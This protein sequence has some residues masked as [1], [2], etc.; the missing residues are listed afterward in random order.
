MSIVKNSTSNVCVLPPVYPIT[1]TRIA[2]LS[3]LEQV[4]RLVDGG[5]TLVQLREKHASP[6]EFYAAAVQCVAYARPSGLKIIINDRV[7][8][9]LMTNADG[10]HLG[11][12]DMPPAAARQVLGPDKIIGYSTHSVDQ[13]I[14]AAAS[15]ADYIAIGPVFE[16]RTKTDPDTAVGLDGVTAVRAAIGNVPLVAIGGIDAENISEVLGAGANS[17]AVISCILA[18]PARINLAIQRLFA[19]AVV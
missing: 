11:Q 17:A 4:K 10:V 6:R 7:D 9:A 2:G 8:I 1:D 16:T 15:D 3:H 14:A 18:E 12:D 13:A 19:A 5:A